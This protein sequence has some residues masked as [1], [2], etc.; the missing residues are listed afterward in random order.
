MIPSESISIS[1]TRS[2]WFEEFIAGIRTHQLMLEK[3]IASDVLIKLY[4]V[5][6]SGNLDQ[7][8]ALNKVNADQHFIKSIIINYIKIISD[9]LPAR[10]AF[11]TD[12]SEVLVWAEIQNDD[13]EM[14]NALLIAEAEINSRFHRYGYDLTSTIVELRDNLQVP[15][16]YSVVI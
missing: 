1:D 10:L 11:D 15:N 8:A 14:E 12:D 6:M 2:T 16:H 9:K 3:R 4:D 13:E 5:L 7:M